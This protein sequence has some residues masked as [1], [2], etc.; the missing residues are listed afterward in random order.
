MLSLE[1]S[2]GLASNSTTLAN[3]F[4]RTKARFSERSEPSPPVS[5]CQVRARPKSWGHPGDDVEVDATDAHCSFTGYV[6]QDA[7]PHASRAVLLYLVSLLLDAEHSQRLS[8]LCTNESRMPASACL[9]NDMSAPVVDCRTLRSRQG[10]L[11][12]H[13]DSDKFG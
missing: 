8:T 4:S 7:S 1:H 10:G 6:A 5:A 12:L 2:T 9:A 3:S 11:Q 13:L